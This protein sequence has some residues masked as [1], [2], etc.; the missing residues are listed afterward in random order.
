MSISSI[1]GG[2]TGEIV[3][4]KVL[5]A[6]NDAEGKASFLSAIT[7]DDTRL[8]GSVLN[9]LTSLSIE[10]L[11]STIVNAIAI[12][13][14]TDEIFRLNPATGTAATPE[15]IN[16]NDIDNYVSFTS[17]GQYCDIELGGSYYIRQYRQYGRVG[18]QL[19]M[20]YSIQYWNGGAWQDCVTDIAGHNVG[21]W[22]EWI[23]FTGVKTTKI[24]IVC[25][26]KSGENNLIPEIEII[27]S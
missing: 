15:R 18:M 23:P 11:T 22:T 13:P 8:D 7:D 19:A 27:G 24:R 21:E 26:T 17:E 5:E 20:R 3:K 1:S 12:N 14:L 10:L 9:A 16:D 2:V 6:L 25:T 4:A